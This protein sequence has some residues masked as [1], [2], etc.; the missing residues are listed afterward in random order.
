MHLARPRIRPR[1][2]MTYREYFNR[3]KRVFLA[4]FLA[5]LAL[6]IAAGGLAVQL[7]WD[8]LFLV[9]YLCI[10]ALFV[11]LYVAVMFG[12]RCPSCGGQ[13]GWIAIYSGGP[14]SIRRRLKFCPYCG[15]SLDDPVP[16][17]GGHQ[18]QGERPPT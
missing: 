18:A 6:G 7:Q 8:W 14:T 11:V 13:W 10:A 16:P 2:T 5:V 12:V 15:V 9:S 4:W 3:R 17:R 1:G